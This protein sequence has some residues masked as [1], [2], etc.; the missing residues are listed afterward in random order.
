MEKE[1][2]LTKL[3]SYQKLSVGLRA[4]LNYSMY[5][6][7]FN[8]MEKISSSSIALGRFCYLAKGGGRIFI[9]D[10]E[11][12][13]E[14]TVMFFQSQDMLPDFKSI[15]KY[16]PGQLFIQFLEDS[17]VLSIPLKHNDNIHKLFHESA[18]LYDEIDAEL[19]AKLIMITI[20]LKTQNAN[21]RLSKL[22]ESI[23]TVFSQTA[24]KD[25]ASYL[26]IHSSTLSAMR[27]RNK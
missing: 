24:V 20:G 11:N 8:R 15:S 2:Y 10:I 17:A 16:M 5:Q 21:Q 19:L 27:N 4:Y 18:N 1:Q 25:V 26:G 23:P 12:E 13:Q 14:I 22:L 7:D 3:S 6:T 9:Y